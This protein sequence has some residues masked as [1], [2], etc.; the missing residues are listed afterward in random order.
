MKVKGQKFTSD[1]LFEIQLFNLSPPSVL[2]FQSHYYEEDKLKEI[3]YKITSIT[4]NAYT[5]IFYTFQ[6]NGET[7]VIVSCRCSIH[8]I[9]DLHVEGVQKICYVHHA[10]NEF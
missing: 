5:G 3:E 7:R 9:Y 6:Q 2:N 4:P 1:Q 10:N 8:N